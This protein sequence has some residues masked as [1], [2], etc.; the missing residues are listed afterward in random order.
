MRNVINQRAK[1]KE[2]SNRAFGTDPSNVL[3]LAY[4]LET[5]PHH[6]FPT[7]ESSASI[8]LVFRTF[9]LCFLVTHYSFSVLCSCSISLLNFIYLFIYF[10]YFASP[11]SYVY[12]NIEDNYKTRQ[13]HH[14][15]KNQ[16]LWAQIN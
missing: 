1:Q 6:E 7:E 10:I 15:S 3:V 8:W 5:F 12:K 2:N 4:F 16:L 13:G 9:F 11:G 14:N